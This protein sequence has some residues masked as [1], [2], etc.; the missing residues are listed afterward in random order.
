[1]PQL[2]QIVKREAER[3]NRQVSRAMKKPELKKQFGKMQRFSRAVG[4]KNRQQLLSQYSQMQK[5]TFASPQTETPGGY[6]MKTLQRIQKT[7]ESFAKELGVSPSDIKPGQLK[8]LNRLA[9]WAESNDALFYEAMRINAQ[10]NFGSNYNFW[11]QNPKYTGPNGIDLLS[12]KENPQGYK[13]ARQQFIKEMIK[14]AN[15][16]IV[17]L[18]KQRDIKGAYKEKMIRGAYLRSQARK[19]AKSRAKGYIGQ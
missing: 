7:R 3:I 9:E 14:E 18:N 16:K 12:E 17:S 11:R 8:E 1:M 2:R 15:A 6:T 19:T 10:K 4:S 13:K 5:A